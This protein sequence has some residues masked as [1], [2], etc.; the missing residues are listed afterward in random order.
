MFSFVVALMLAAF[1]ISL[2]G[3]TT[4]LFLLR[5][6]EVFTHRLALKPALYVLFMPCSFGYYQVLPGTS[7]LKKVY[8]IVVV[9]TF[10]LMLIGSIFVIYTHFF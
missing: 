4:L 10:V 2:I 6:V 8:Q 3:G 5:L 9:L 7:I 1:W